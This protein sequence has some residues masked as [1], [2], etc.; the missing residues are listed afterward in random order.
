M[1]RRRKFCIC[2]GDASPP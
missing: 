1:A 2:S